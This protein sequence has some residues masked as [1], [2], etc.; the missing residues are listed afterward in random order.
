MEKRLGNDGRTSPEFRVEFDKVWW[1][2]LSL[3]DSI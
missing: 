3:S 1:G 2:F